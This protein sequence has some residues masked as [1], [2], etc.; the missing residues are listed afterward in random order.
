M[1]ATFLLCLVLLAAG[2]SGC[3]THRPSVL[4]VAY[5][6]SRYNLTFYLPADWHGYLVQTRQWNG[7]TYAQATDRDEV[8]TH[9]QMIDILRGAQGKTG[10]P[11]QDIPIFIFTRQQWDDM[12]HGKF[13]D[14]QYAGGVIYEMWHNDDYVFGISSRFNVDDSVPGWDV[15]QKNVDQNCAAHPMPHLYPE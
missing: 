12:H 10:K 13:V 8:V 11:Y 14:D 3:S 2:L 7:I 6:N 9:G 1:K 4:P 5:H 15:A